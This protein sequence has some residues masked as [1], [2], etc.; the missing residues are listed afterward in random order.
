MDWRLK[1]L[2]IGNVKKYMQQNLIVIL[3]FKEITYFSS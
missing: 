3:F 2:Q 1:T